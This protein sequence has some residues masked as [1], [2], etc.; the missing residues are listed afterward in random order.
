MADVNKDAAL[1]AARDIAQAGGRA[2]PSRWTRPTKRRSNAA[3]TEVVAAWHGV[4]VLVSN[5]GIRIVHPI[6]EFPFADWK[7]M[8]AIHLDGAFLTTRAC[9]PHMPASD[10]GGGSI[11]MGSVHSK[12]PRCSNRPT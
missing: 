3:I 12:R 6:V 1:A 10:R 8:L 11:Y 2:M 5:A 7:K 4:D 9:M